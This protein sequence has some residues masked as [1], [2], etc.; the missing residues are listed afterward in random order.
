MHLGTCDEGNPADADTELLYLEFLVFFGLV[1]RR[2]LQFAYLLTLE[3]Q[4]FLEFC[5]VSVTAGDEMKGATV[6]VFFP[7]SSSIWLFADMKT[8]SAWII[9]RIDARR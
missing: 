3:L 6:P 7:M 8:R 2:I 1:P 4:V 5:R 9:H